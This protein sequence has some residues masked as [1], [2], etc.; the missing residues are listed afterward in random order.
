MATIARFAIPA[1]DFPLGRIFDDLPNTTVEIERVVPTEQ[2]LLPY[3]WVADVERTN[4]QGFLTAEPAFESVTRIDTL[5]GREL[6]RARWN[7][8]VEGVLTAILES[9]LTVLSALGT[10][11]RWTFEFRADDPD[12]ISAFHQTCA[13]CDIAVQLERLQSLAENQP[14]HSHGLTANQ[15][16]ALLL[17]F[18][19]GYYDQPRTTNLETLADQ[20]D[21]SRSS[22]SDRLRRGY[23]NLLENT[24]VHT[25]TA[26]NAE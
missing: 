7:T 21:I 2:D 5:D 16:E 25:Y 20:L 6:F 26:N 4:V 15:H 11:E 24:I 14:T 19:E 8:D 3:F 17:A 10:H 12:Q 13:D 22:F 18:N 9:E 1:D 23:Y